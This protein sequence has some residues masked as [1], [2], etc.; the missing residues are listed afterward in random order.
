MLFCINKLNNDENGSVIVVAL[1]LMVIVSIIGVSATNISTVEVQ[2]ASN[3]H[4]YRIAFFNAD[5]GPYAVPKL[6]SRAVNTSTI[7]TAANFGFAYIPYSGGASLPSDGGTR[8]YNQIYGFDTYDAENDVSFAGTQANT[9]TE[10][11]IERLR[12]Q[13]V[14]GGGAEFSAATEGIGAVSVAV[15]YGLNSSG[16]GPRQSNSFVVGE[17]RKVVDM[18]GGL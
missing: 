16:T 12:Q 11:D 1:F 15:F 13:S 5:S 10:V 9:G 3:D 8:I 7:Q 14:I 18:P 4:F 17:Y 6:I 2:I